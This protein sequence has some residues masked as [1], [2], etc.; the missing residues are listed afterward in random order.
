MCNFETAFLPPRSSE[1]LLKSIQ[2]SL[3]GDVRCTYSLV[4]K[5]GWSPWNLFKVKWS[6]EEASI[7]LSIYLFIPGQVIRWRSSYLSI[8]L[9]IYTTKKNFGLIHV[10]FLSASNRIYLYIYLSIY[11]TIYLYIYLSIY[12]SF[13]K[14]IYL[15]ICLSI[16][17]SIYI[18][19]YLSFY[20]SIYLF[21][22]L[23]I[24]LSI[25][26]YIYLSIDYP[27]IYLSIYLSIYFRSSDQRE[28]HTQRESK[29]QRQ[30]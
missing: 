4:L 10:Y 28:K 22:Y 24:Y 25:Y 30:R 26:T 2:W 17:L 6:K 8:Y 5:N 3:K 9:S 13:Y 18:S 1:I 27:S 21:I 7:Y 20:I 14:Y 29:E 23:S 11:L 15:Y 12:P 19:I 16:Y